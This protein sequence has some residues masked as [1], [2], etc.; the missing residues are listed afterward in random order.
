MPDSGRFFDGFGITLRVVGIRLGQCASVVDGDKEFQG[1][2]NIN[3]RGWNGEP[4]RTDPS[5]DD[6]TN[7]DQGFGLPIGV[8]PNCL[9]LRL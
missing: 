8:C 5:T 1:I 3:S 2:D 7:S 9:G 4:N 6:R